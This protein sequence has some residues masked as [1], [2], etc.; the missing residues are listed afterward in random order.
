[1]PYIVEFIS[2]TESKFSDL[3]VAWMNQKSKR[4]WQNCMKLPLKCAIYYAKNGAT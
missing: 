1:M 4:N 3:E 2:S